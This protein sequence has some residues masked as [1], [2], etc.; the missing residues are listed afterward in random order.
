MQHDI[1]PPHIHLEKVNPHINFDAIPAV[2]P[3]KAMEWK[4]SVD[5]P[6]LVGISSFGITGTDAHI[7]IQEPPKYTPSQLHTSL[8]RPLHLLTISAK[9]DAGLDNVLEKYVSFLE[10]NEKSLALGDVAYT[11]NT[12]RA[13]FPYR[14]AIV[15][16]DVA[17]AVKKVKGSIQGAKKHTPEEQPKLCFL[18]TGRF[19]YFSACP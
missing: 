15:A 16:K 11:A 9:S 7:I 3:L 8:Q 12:G 1:I 6:R 4:G 10:K 2:V 5:K 17:D 13:H 19:T 14:V 18:F